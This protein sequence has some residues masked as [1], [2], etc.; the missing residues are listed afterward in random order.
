MNR[1][2]LCIG[3]IV[4]DA[5]S[6]GLFLGGAPLNVASHLHALDQ[7]VTLAGR[8]GDDRLGEE[9]RRRMKARGLDHSLV[10]VDDDLP[11][12]FVRVDLTDTGEPEYEIPEPAAWD[13]I[14]PTETLQAAAER[15]DVLIFGSLAQRQ[16]PSR[17]TIQ[18][19][20]RDDCLTVFDAN[21]RPPFV[22]RTVVERSLTAADVVKVNER[23]FRRL[24]EWYR[25]PPHPAS[26]L[27]QLASRIDCRI[28][29]V[30]RG[31]AGALLW[32][33]NGCVQHSGYAVDVADPVGAGDA[34]LAALVTGIAA[35][36]R[37]DDILDR[38]NRLGAYVASRPGAVPDY[39]LNTFAEIDRLPLQSS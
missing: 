36:H 3:E 6:D 38:A 7:D 14:P 26:A 15:A 16:T 19:L 34:F 21:L 25:L 24:T 27:P 23:E 35:G 2:I 5:L 37:K 17:E 28:L 4:W 32:S 9:A 1:E 31:E 12:G 33:K 13:A 20:F 39:A 22:S 8:V 30:T 11:T 10:G 29:C 18:A